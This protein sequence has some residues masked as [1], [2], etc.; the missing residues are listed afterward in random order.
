[1]VSQG[2]RRTQTAEYWRDEFS[3]NKEDVEYLY[4]WL[5][6]EGEPRTSEDLSLKLIER[7][8]QKEEIAL[9]KQQGGQI[10]VPN[11]AYEIGQSIAFPAFEYAIGQVVGIREGNNPRYGAFK[12]VRVQLEGEDTQ[13]EF[14]S[15]FA[16][17]HLLRR[18]ASSLEDGSELVSP[19]QLYQEHGSSIR[20]RVEDALREND[21]FVFLEGAWFLK[22]L[23]P[24]VTP[25]QMNIAE[26]IIDERG[27]PVTVDQLADGVSQVLREMGTP[28]PGKST[29]RAYA[30]AHTLGKDPR[31]VEIRSEGT[32]AWYLSDAVPEAVRH[33]PARLVPMW[34]THGRELL[35]RE[36]RD[37]AL[38]IL[39]EADELDGAPAA[40]GS[41]NSVQIAL[42]FPHR[43]EGTFPLS[44]RVLGLLAEKPPADRFMV[45]F[46]DQETGE[47]VPG[48]M[49]PVQ[50]YA[51][52][53]GEWYRRHELPVGSIV[54]LDR[55]GDPLDFVVSCD[56]KRKSDW[57]REAKVVAGRLVFGI[58]R[59]AYGC[60]FDK[61]LV[62]DEGS[63]ID[64]D[65]LWVSA[66]ADP[67]GPTDSL[68]DQLIRIFPELAKLSSQ[69]LVHAKTLY[70]AVNLTRR[71][72]AVPIFAE[73]TRR[74]CFDPVGDGNWVY[75]DSLRSAI[76]ETAEDMSRRPNSH[77]Q[78]LI[79]DRVYP[80][81]V[82][83]NEVKNQ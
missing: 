41:L 73:L 32:S 28:L 35:S 42:T 14:A 29:V 66:G 59:K 57:V 82:S 46:H 30:M 72:G 8:C 22:G 9:S 18:S 13:R 68:F 43:R 1:V 51:W 17:D 58:Q 12:V 33:K 15:E 76:Y 81:G 37:F 80:Y 71:C 31:F 54:E 36:L 47:T 62:I 64:L 40:F 19:R 11:E 83:A 60:R 61:H 69:G 67:L 48:W 44:K 45:T 20:G 55:G 39:D 38:E 53:L 56:G 63:L 2:Q 79:V 5:V 77:R 75:D 70:S 6:E 21:D 49:I 7:R 50:G 26:A 78:D 16:P 25:F 3:A 4:E 27:Q 24:E 10:Y 23:M 52:G 34:A 74:A 65:R